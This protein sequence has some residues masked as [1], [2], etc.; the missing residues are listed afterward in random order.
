MVEARI[1]WGGSPGQMVSSEIKSPSLWP[2]CG[3]FLQQ[4]AV[5][6]FNS[7]VGVDDLLGFATSMVLG[8]KR[9]LSNKSRGS[10]NR[11]WEMTGDCIDMAK[12]N[13]NSLSDH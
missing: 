8:M 13:N 9:P 7:T 6:L 2:L 10:V 3:H 5:G 12:L 4:R 11:T 1:I